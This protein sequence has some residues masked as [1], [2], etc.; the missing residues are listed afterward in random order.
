MGNHV[1]ISYS[2]KDRTYARNL[3]NDLRKRG[4]EV[5][6][7]DRI[8][9]GDRWW[10][11]IDQAICTGAAFIVVMTP[12][13]Q[14]SEWVERE[15]LLAQR[16][17]KP[18]FPLLLRGKEFSLLI[19]TQYAD[20]TNGQMPPD[21]FYERLRRAL[22]TSGVSGEGAKVQIEAPS[23]LRQALRASGVPDSPLPL[24]PT[25]QPSP[26]GTEPR[27][28][29]SASVFVCPEC[30][31]PFQ[32][33]ANLETHMANRHPP[34][35]A[36]QKPKPA[37]PEGILVCS[38]CGLPFQEKA[39][40]ETHVANRHPLVAARQKPKL[41]IP[42][43]TLVCPEC[44]LPFKRKTDFEAHMANWHPPATARTKSR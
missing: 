36:R 8:D 39:N 41:A 19:T 12:D 24:K 5:W 9:Y 26:A 18:I 16:E 38:E 23:V 43:G 4:F 27:P 35:A 15:I 42:R 7:D 37:V 40:L 34:V 10:R 30:G 2:R 14:E 21:S 1:F 13:A 17:Q 22:Q 20:V 32:E 33:K 3:A 31:L 28:T 29:T 25:S 6:I 11:T 44:G